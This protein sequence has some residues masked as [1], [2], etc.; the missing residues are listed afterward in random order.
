MDLETFLLIISSGLIAYIFGRFR[1]DKKQVFNKKLEIYSNI[2]FEISNH[3]YGR[4]SNQSEGREKLVRLFSPA[5]LIGSSEVIKELR[6]YYSLV[7]E[8]YEQNDSGQKNTIMN[9]ITVSGMEL[10][11]LMRKD[12]V[13]NRDLLKS[14]IL[15]STTKKL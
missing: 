3:N 10:E 12:L 7:M 14:E 15:I 13:G 11:Q 2:V 1:D 5:R 4:V 8:F 6:E 9:K